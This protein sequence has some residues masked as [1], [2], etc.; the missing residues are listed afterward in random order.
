MRGKGI[1]KILVISVILAIVASSVVIF[2]GVNLD[3]GIGEKG[4]EEGGGKGVLSLVPPPFIGVAGASGVKSGSAFPEDEAG[5]SAYVNIGQI[6]ASVDES[7]DL[8]KAK[9]AFFSTEDENRTYVIGQIA[10]DKFDKERVAPH[11]YVTSDGWIVAYFLKSE[12]SSKVTPWFKYSEPITETTLDEAIR[13]IWAA[14]TSDF[15]VVIDYNEAKGNIKYYDF[16]FPEANKI[17]LIVDR[18]PAPRSWDNPP[19][20][21]SF[22]LTIPVECRLYEASW[23]TYY[24]NVNGEA[25][26]SNEHKYIIDELRGTGYVYGEFTE[27]QLSADGNV[28]TITFSFKGCSG[29]E[30]GVTVALVYH[31][32]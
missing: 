15:S 17:M 1:W 2:S 25:M 26:I 6:I 13:K 27:K 21:D 28:H 20:I 12:E 10:L 19:R 4:L 29:S 3:K 24:N 23:S 7:I 9:G 31:T 30:A 32:E 8:Q 5:I 16:G 14:I 11:V 22:N 18:A